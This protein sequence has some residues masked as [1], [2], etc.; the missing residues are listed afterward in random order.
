[1]SLLAVI[2]ARGGSK[3]VPRKNIKNFHGKPLIAWAIE[4][5]KK[6][7]YIDRLIVSTDD[8]EIKEI[9][10]LYGAEAPFVRPE[11]L[12]QDKSAGVDV[13]RHASGIFPEY[14][15]VVCLQPTSPFRSV[16]D[17]DGIYKY[18][19]KNNLNCVLPITIAD[20]SPYWFV[21]KNSDGRISPIIKGIVEANRQELPTTYVLCGTVFLYKADWLNSASMGVLNDQSYGFEIP[22]ERSYEI[23]S[24]EDWDFAEY[25]MSKKM[26]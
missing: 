24:V 19:E 6:S 12:S 23:D 4:E 16:K 13:M 2:P 5:A 22:K 15:W 10:E 18:G 11:N 17:I 8:A 14:K 26:K 3:G 20:K 21:S 1:M 7:K 25:L 9:S